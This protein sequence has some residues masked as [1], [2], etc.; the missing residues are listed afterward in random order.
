MERFVSFEVFSFILDHDEH[1]FRKVED[2]EEKSSETFPYNN[3][4]DAENY[5]RRGEMMFSE[6]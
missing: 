1:K 6:K 2:E 4:A 5:D 3:N